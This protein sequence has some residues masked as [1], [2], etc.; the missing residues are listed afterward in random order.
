VIRSLSRYPIAV[1][2]LIADAP[3]ELA[4]TRPA[5]E[6]IDVRVAWM[7]F[8]ENPNLQETEHSLRLCYDRLLTIWQ[9]EER[10]AEM[11]ADAVA[12]DHSVASMLREA[13]CHVQ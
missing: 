10:Y 6:F 3:A 7:L 12:L 1:G 5:Q 9:I 4:L 11:V 8:L 13:A 2:E